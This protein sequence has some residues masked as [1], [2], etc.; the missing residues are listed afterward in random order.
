[1]FNSEDTGEITLLIFHLIV[2]W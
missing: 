1:M 2:H